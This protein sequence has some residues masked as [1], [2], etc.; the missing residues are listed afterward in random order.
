MW[1]RASC[2]LLC[3]FLTCSAYAKTDMTLQKQIEQALTKQLNAPVC[4]TKLHLTN[5]NHTTNASVED[6]HIDAVRQ[7][8]RAHLMQANDSKGV[9]KTPITGSFSFAVRV[10]I[11]KRALSRGETIYSDDILW[12]T[13]PAS[14]KTRG[15]VKSEKGLHHAHAVQNLP[16][17]SILRE[18]QL[19]LGQT[20]KKGSTVKMVYK[21]GAIEIKA[22]GAKLVRD[23]KVGDHVSVFPAY[24]KGRKKTISG[25][26]TSPSEV[27]IS[28]G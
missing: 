7:K 2:L 19:T 13:V 16:A 11:L 28:G 12:D 1:L 17:G 21:A 9:H 6:I 20:I 18:E 27:V 15:A 22:R 4:V 5:D 23:A 25:V 26:L 8:F 3:S 14:L 24:Q 10:P